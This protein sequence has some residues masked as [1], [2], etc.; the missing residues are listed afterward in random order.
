MA[1][2]T[3]CS[4][5]R[6]FTSISGPQEAYEFLLSRINY[7]RTQFVPYR[8][9]HFKLD[10]MQ[11]LAALVGNPQDAFPIIHIAG[12]K[13]KGSTATMIAASLQAADLTTG[14]YTSPHLERIEERIVVNGQLCPPEELARLVAGM[15][16]AV[17]SLDAAAA[18]GQP[19]GRGPTYFEILTVLAW[20]Y[21][22]RRQVDVAVVEV[23]LG[24][25]L[26][27]TN[28]CTP[29][30]SVIT[31]ISRD[32]TRQLGF[33]LDDI[34]REKAGIIKPGVPVVSGV[35]L[36]VARD[37]I[38]QVA[39]A[40]HCPLLE[41]G[42][43]FHVMPHPR[44]GGWSLTYQEG[45]GDEPW[46]L[47]QVPLK[48]LGRHQV[49]NAAVAAASLSV[50]RDRFPRLTPQSIATG[51]RRANPA[52]R[53][54][55]VGD[56]PV[57]IVDV[58]HNPA[59]I[60]ALLRTLDDHWG[61][62]DRCFVFAATRGKEYGEM[63]RQILP[64]CRRLVLTQYQD[65]PRGVD[66]S[67]LET[68]ARAGMQRLNGADRPQIEVQPMPGDAWRS[69]HEQACEDD[70]ICI[71]GSFFLAAELRSTVIQSLSRRPVVD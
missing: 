66:V 45:F 68:H 29:V 28:V 43:D 69:A 60:E 38:R 70:V 53:I 47:S 46:T 25:R 40:H 5:R 17:E 39:A 67:Q 62:R 54:E 27:S 34:A 71:T 50:V 51:L 61:E 14:L 12:S 63:I 22:S 3:S 4:G 36:P 24:G 8:E 31:S 64:H 37:V 65:N 10:R 59:S 11:E 9:N 57:V 2:K 58:S 44:D 7:E 56:R 55:V 52:A 42:R 13:G 26:D 35:R 32:H 21:F 23:G 18:T 15:A 20:T 33:A 16:P 49:D 48:L 19:D 1:D 6:A 41:L 30:C